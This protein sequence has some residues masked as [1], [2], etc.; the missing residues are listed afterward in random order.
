VLSEEERAAMAHLL[1]LFLRNETASQA[2]TYMEFGRCTHRNDYNLMIS[3]K[4]RGGR[5][6]P[7]IMSVQAVGIK[8]L[9]ALTP[10]PMPLEHNEI[11]ELINLLIPEKEVTE[12]EATL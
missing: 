2:P 1:E 9:N 12:A 6:L 7:T 8:L 10:K 5:I 11:I 3:P 4:R